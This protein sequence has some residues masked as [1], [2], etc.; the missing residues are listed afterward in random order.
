MP[1]PHTLRDEKIIFTLEL[2]GYKPDCLS[3]GSREACYSIN[4]TLIFGKH[5]V[6]TKLCISDEN[7]LDVN[8]THQVNADITITLKPATIASFPIT[9]VH[10]T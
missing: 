7:L 10:Q 9:Y 5:L 8:K 4:T 1:E 2:A 3:P 6:R